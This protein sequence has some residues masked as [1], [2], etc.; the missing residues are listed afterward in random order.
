MRGWGNSAQITHSWGQDP[1]ET[2]GDSSLIAPWLD[3][4]PE[5]SSAIQTTLEPVSLSCL[6]P[7]RLLTVVEL[8]PSPPA[9][10]RSFLSSKTSLHSASLRTMPHQPSIGSI[11]IFKS[12]RSSDPAITDFGSLPPIISTG[13]GEP[14]PSST[15]NKKPKSLLS[16]LKRKASRANVRPGSAG[17]DGR[18][19]IILSNNV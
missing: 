15:V 5:T 12:A 18:L 9:T 16:R 10:K 11:S 13:Y 14:G 2:A 1:A 17:D 19:C 8:K 7:L 3:D 4:A 6:E